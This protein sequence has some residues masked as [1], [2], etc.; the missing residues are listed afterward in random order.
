M[1]KKRELTA[2]AMETIR[3]LRLIIDVYCDGSQQVLADKS[4]VNKAS[5]SQYL[6][7]NNVPSSINAK[8]IADAFGIN[9]AWI[10]GFDVPLHEEPDPIKE[11]VQ[12]MKDSPKIRTLLSSTK[13]LNEKDLSL[14]IDMV[15]RL[16]ESYK[17]S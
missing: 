14:V 9:P 12:E 3:R 16:R 17:D 4:G 5:I 1:K 15:N 8:K 11:M 7:Y 13:G 2:A 6:H 10:M